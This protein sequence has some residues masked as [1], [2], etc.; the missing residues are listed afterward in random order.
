MNPAIKVVRTMQVAFIVSVLLFYYVC[1]TLHPIDPSKPP[2]A[3][4]MGWGLV[5][6]AIAS[7]LGG[8]LFQQMLRGA[9]MPSDPATR[10]VTARS[11]WLSGHIVRFATE[12]SVALFGFVLRFL[13]G[14]STQV[15]LLF[16]GSLLLLLL[17]QPGAFPTMAGSQDGSVN[18]SCVL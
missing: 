9:P 1:S 13:G 3:P 18:R 2:V 16:G 10:D 17:W 11:R 14:P 5:F 4:S 6:C 8:F 7:A 15:Y 12:E